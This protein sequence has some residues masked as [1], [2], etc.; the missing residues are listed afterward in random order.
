MS[1]K[2]EETVKKERR[3][4]FAVQWRL[5]YKNLHFSDV[6]IKP[7]LKFA[8]ITPLNGLCLYLQSQNKGCRSDSPYFTVLLNRLQ[9]PNLL[10]IIVN[11][12]V[13]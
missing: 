6:R 7:S 1:L 11:G 4:L 9:A 2:P 10:I 5:L 8:V 13:A 12:S 3:V